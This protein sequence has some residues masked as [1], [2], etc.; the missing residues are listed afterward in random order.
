MKC[1]AEYIAKWTNEVGTFCSS[2]QTPAPN[3]R[4]YRRLPLWWRCGMIR[5][6][7]WGTTG[8][9]MCVCYTLK[10]C[11]KSPLTLFG[12]THIFSYA[13]S[14][15]HIEQSSV[16]LHFEGFS[17]KFVLSLFT[18]HF[19]LKLKSPSLRIRSFVSRPSLERRPLHLLA[20]KGERINPS[21][22][23]NSRML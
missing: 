15:T 8:R 18:R 11:K 23:G 5:M 6:G 14:C 10:L 16:S 13:F 7:L 4:R 21:A 3:R 9:S 2:K 22:A 12:S 20:W 17:S 1:S 19:S